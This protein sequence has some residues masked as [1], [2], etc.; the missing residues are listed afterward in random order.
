LGVHG[1]A[2]NNETLKEYAGPFENFIKVI[3]YFSVVMDDSEE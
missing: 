2:T 3:I 1:E